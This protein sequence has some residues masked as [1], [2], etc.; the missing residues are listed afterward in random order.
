[1]VDGSASD[2][3]LRGIEVVGGSGIRRRMGDVI[4]ARGAA[5]VPTETALRPN[6]PNPFNPETWIPFDLARA[7]SV[8][9][10]VYDSR[11]VA[12]RTWDLGSLDAG[13]YG[14]R[15]GAVHWDGR[16]ASGEAAASGAYYVE[17]RAGADVSVRRLLLAK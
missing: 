6:F 13:S 15:A 10:T 9:V 1:V 2:V 11:G 3:A 17:L 8:V 16:D 14:G 4:L 7:S 5:G 12:V